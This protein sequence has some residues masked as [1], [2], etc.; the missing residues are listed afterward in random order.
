VRRLV[1]VALLVLLIAGVRACG[2]PAVA[3]DRLGVASRWVADQTGLS[4]AKDGWDSTV[5]PQVA[6]ATRSSS[7][8]VYGAMSS[9]MDRLETT[10]DGIAT[11]IAAAVSNAAQ[12]LR[13]GIRSIFTSK[14]TPPPPVAPPVAPP[15]ASKPDK[16]TGA[17]R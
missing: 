1:H 10:A 11:S 4:T 9:A 3:E 16:S 12:S 14:E 7:D 13:T 15:D 2:G 8:A 6:A 17:S 5:R